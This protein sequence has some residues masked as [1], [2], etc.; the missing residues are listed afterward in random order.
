[1]GSAAIANHQQNQNQLMQQQ[2]QQQPPQY[3]FKLDSREFD[4]PEARAGHSLASTILHH[5]NNLGLSIFEN[6][7]S[8]GAQ[9]ME[10]QREG[11]QTRLQ[12]WL[13]VR[14]SVSRLSLVP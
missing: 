1:L 12:R 2:Q 7:A 8:L 10:S 14:V 5:T 3:Y 4:K 13:W 9:A 11:V 6:A